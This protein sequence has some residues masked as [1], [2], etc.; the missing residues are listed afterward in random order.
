M[1]LVRVM[2]SGLTS[3]SRDT[4]EI[5]SKE[6][7]VTPIEFRQPRHLATFGYAHILSRCFDA[8]FCKHDKTQLLAKFKKIL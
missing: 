2:N 4:G 6:T 8:N 1:Q 3:F 5:P 7:F